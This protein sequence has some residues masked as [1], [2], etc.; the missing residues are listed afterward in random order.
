MQRK[1]VRRLEAVM[2]NRIGKN[3]MA[4]LAGVHRNTLNRW[5][6]NDPMA[7]KPIVCAGQRDKWDRVQVEAWIKHGPR[8]A[9]AMMEEEDDGRP[10]QQQAGRR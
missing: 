4:E 3:E 10:A 1:P 8:W 5:L 2:P 6:E 7:P 9:A